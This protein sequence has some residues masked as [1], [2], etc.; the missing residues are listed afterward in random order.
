MEKVR[1]EVERQTSIPGLTSEF[2]SKQSKNNT[3]FKNKNRNPS[4]PIFNAPAIC[5]DF[6]KW[7]RFIADKEILS[8]GRE[9]GK[10]T[11][12]SVFYVGR[13]VP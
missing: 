1:Q 10:L 6:P 2:G 3:D 4:L 5:T 8:T 11:L 7:E 13:A 9:K 12:H